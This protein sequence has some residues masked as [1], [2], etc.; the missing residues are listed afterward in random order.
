MIPNDYTQTRFALLLEHGTVEVCL[1]PSGVGLW[2]DK[3]LLA[4]TTTRFKGS[5]SIF[6]LSLFRRDHRNQAM[7]AKSSN[8]LGF[9]KIS[10]TRFLNVPIE[11]LFLSI[12][13]KS[14]SQTW[15][16]EAESQ[17]VC[18]TDLE[19][20]EHWWHVSSVVILRFSKFSFVGRALEQ[21]FHKKCLIFPGICDF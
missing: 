17:S 4:S 11:A 16:R 6:N 8:M 14:M 2:R 3:Y 21:A 5:T 19:R 9:S 20:E 13:W 18:K 1:K 10:S 15:W 12:Q 7:T